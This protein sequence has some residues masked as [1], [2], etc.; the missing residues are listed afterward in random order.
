MKVCKL[1]PVNVFDFA[2][3]IETDVVKEIDK[4]HMVRRG[5][6]VLNSDLRL[7]QSNRFDELVINFNHCLKQVHEYYN[8]DCTGF[9]I[10]SMWANKY[11]PGT[12]Q[13]P[14]RHANA[15][16]SGNFY[17]TGG[18]PTL[19]YDPIHDRAQGQMEI[20]TLP[21]MS[22]HGFDQNGPY[23]ERV[24]AIRNRLII[25]PSW[26]WHSTAAAEMDRY[27]ISFNALPYGPINGGIANLEIL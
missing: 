26:F 17:A 15:Y 27:T 14:H 12:A 23:V 21:K 1:Y 18:S 7:H 8:Y 5:S 24:T 19:F 3:D 20:F 10:S 4:L 6:G 16:W 11:E 22:K 13:E 2:L 25:F 9:R